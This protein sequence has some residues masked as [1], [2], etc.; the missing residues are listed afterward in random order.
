M[1]A[2][3]TAASAAFPQPHRAAHWPVLARLALSSA[4]ATTLLASAPQ[5]QASLV[6]QQYSL[7]AGA[8]LAALDAAVAAGLPPMATAEVGS[9]NFSSRSDGS[10]GYQGDHFGGDVAWPS[11][12][13]F[14]PALPGNLNFGAVIR[15]RVYVANAGTYTFGTNS[16]DGS[17]LV[18]DGVTLYNDPTQ[19]AAV[20]HYA[21]MS[22]GEGYHELVLSYFNGPGAADLELFAA[23]GRRSG[24]DSSFRL[25]G[26]TA[27]G[28]LAATLPEPATL[29]LAS[30]ALVGLGLGRR[31]TATRRGHAAGPA[32]SLG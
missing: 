19:H 9:I 6:V 31:R 2:A 8:N 28:G 16:D 4:L 26:D 24:F 20:D 13:A 10:A 11:T 5:A 30:A 23:Q 25:V 22:L 29:G 12:G 14:D 7:N 1:Q 18:I 32:P 27:G 17:R 3:N 15:T 21:T